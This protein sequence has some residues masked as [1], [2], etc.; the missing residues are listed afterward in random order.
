MEQLL[1]IQFLK[2]FFWLFKAKIEQYKTSDNN[3]CGIIIWPDEEEKQEFIFKN[4]FDILLLLK[5]KFLCDYL[6]EHNL[7]HGDQII[8]SESELL[9]ELRKEDWN[10]IDAKN[11]INF[12]CNF[13]VK[14]VDDGEETDSFFVHF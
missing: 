13:S 11:S 8:I 7:M 5:T 10:E 1:I 14:M 9:K 12:L 4:E 6:S 3:I 2:S